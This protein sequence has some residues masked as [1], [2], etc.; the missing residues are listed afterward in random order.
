MSPSC[1]L[2]GRQLGY[3]MDLIASHVYG[4]RQGGR[5]FVA[6]HVHVR[7]SMATTIFVALWSPAYYLLGDGQCRR[8]LIAV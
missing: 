4:R 1:H 8:P 2:L 3:E 7:A 5:Q 6:S